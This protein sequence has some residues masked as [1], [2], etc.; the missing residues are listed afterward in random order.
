[1][2]SVSDE[3]AWRERR[4]EHRG[5]GLKIMDGLMDQVNVHY[6]DAG[7]VVTMR[8]RLTAHGRE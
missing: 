1:M 8:R 6:A 4:G 7:T 3:G 2:A 5:R